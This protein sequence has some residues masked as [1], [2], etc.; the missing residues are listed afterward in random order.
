MF[1]A[2]FTRATKCAHIF[3]RTIFLISD[4][5][6]KSWRNINLHGIY[7]ARIQRAKIF[8]Q[9][10]NIVWYKKTKNISKIHFIPLLFLAFF[11]LLDSTWLN[12][13]YTRKRN[14][15]NSIFYFV[16]RVKNARKSQGIICIFNIFLFLYQTI[17]ICCLIYILIFLLSEYFCF[18]NVSTKKSRVN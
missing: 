15:L 7:C 9:P 11:T 1:K 13:V 8:R 12:I 14:F 4:W 2:G 5:L 6:I 10:I 16:R 17:F 18:L 3:V